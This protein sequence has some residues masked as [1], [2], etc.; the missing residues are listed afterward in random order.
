VRALA[1]LVVV[2][3]SLALAACAG[4][5]PKHKL[6]AS[7][8]AEQARSD[9]IVCPTTPC[10]PASPLLELGDAALAASTADAPRHSVVMLDG[11]LDSL[12]ARVHLIDSARRTIDLQ[13]FHFEQD[14]SGRLVLDALMNASRRG[15][16][17]RLLMD[18]LSGLDE[19]RIWS[20]LAGYHKNF[21]LRMYNPLF[22]KAQFGPLEFVAGVVFQFG[23]LNRRMHNKV[24]VVDGSIGI[25]GGRNIQDEYFDWHP[26]YDY[27]D[28]DVAVAGPAAKSMTENFEAFWEDERTLEPAELSD[29]A[30]LLI[31]EKGPVAQLHMPARTPRVEAMAR[32]AADPAAVFAR[33]AP[34]R[35]DVGR[36]DYIG[37]LPS[38]HDAAAERH[39][40]ASHQ[41]RDIVAGAREEVLLQTPYLV[42]SQPARQLFREMQAREDS[43]RIRV[44]T[45]SLAA[46][47]AFPAYAM[48][49]KYK[50]LYL[51]ELGFEIHEYK[52]FPD[53]APIDPEATGAMGADAA[54]AATAR[55]G[56]PDVPWPGAACC[57]F[58][59]LP[60]GDRP[61]L[62]VPAPEDA[63]TSSPAPDPGTGLRRF[64]RLGPVPLKS[65]G[66]RIGLHAKS[67]VIDRRIAVVGSHNFDP[68]SDEFNTESM[69]VVYDAAFATRLAESIERDMAPGNAWVIA[70]R[71]KLPILRG[72]NYSLGKIS[73]KLPVFDIWPLPYATSYEIKPG[74]APLP[75]TSPDFHAC[76]TPV[77]DFPE[78]NLTLKGI[79]TRVLTV[80][81][82]GLIPI[83]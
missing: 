39:T 64:R 32:A 59:V 35:V 44:S 62:P 11:G 77:G 58:A 24:M 68:R 54:A 52:P 28:R 37:D 15:V 51:R 78:V 5:S 55:A 45:N 7:T 46:T 14:D 12:L 34:Y 10:A 27:R 22:R 41:M 3:A 47:D 65:A 66:L 26:T 25:V 81:G 2:A 80:F 76:Y 56:L 33:L 17:V 67:L 72:L 70:P 71:P 8:L 20:H 38:K 4:V 29:V 30:A 73:E 83:I 40:Q 1:R 18:Q 63:V 36:V 82:A 23:S 69:V 16:R 42:M 6:E 50:R 21:E 74:C 19:A 43:P 31:R 75:P 53:D 57:D 48:S 79:Y 13:T 49:H 61:A 9:E 60:A